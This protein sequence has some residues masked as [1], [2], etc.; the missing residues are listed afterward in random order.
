MRKIRGLSLL[1]LALVFQLVPDGAR[2]SS[3]A[4]PTASPPLLTLQRQWR[5]AVAGLGIGVAGIVA[6]DIDNDGIVDIVCS[7]VSG[8]SSY[9][10]VL[11]HLP[12]IAGYTTT[13]TSDPLPTIITS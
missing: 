10:Y 13:W 12:G 2:P 11:N 8:G 3:A 5:Y 4:L 9:W 1:L 7:A 6:A